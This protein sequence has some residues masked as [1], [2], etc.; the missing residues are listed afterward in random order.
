MSALSPSRAEPLIS[1][2]PPVMGGTENAADRNPTRLS[3]IRT[4][5]LLF[6]AQPRTVNEVAAHLGRPILHIRASLSAAKRLG[7]VKRIA[8]ATYVRG[9]DASLMPCCSENASAGPLS[10]RR[11]G[12]LFPLHAIPRP[13]IVA[14][15]EELG[16]LATRS[17]PIREA[18]LLFLSQ[19]RTAREIAEHINRPV[20]TATG[21]LSAALKRGLVKRMAGSAYVRSDYADAGSCC[22]S[23]A[24]RRATDRD[25]IIRARLLPLLV[26][27][28]HET[29]LCRLA[30]AALPEVRRVL[31]G[32]WLNGW[33]S[34]DSTAG[35]R[36]APWR[37]RRNSA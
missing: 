22:P 13:E 19:P 32:I 36:L 20:P 5:L 26:E 33:L 21:H 1:R 7:L 34:G 14:L 30:D 29:E 9:D 31:H 12:G 3:P 16:P 15:H 23:P 6:L 28:R 4:A 25:T 10:S 2:P 18:I 11:N 8:K 37:L 24:R 35:Y 27:R 17:A